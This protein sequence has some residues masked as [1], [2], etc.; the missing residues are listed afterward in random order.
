MCLKRSS[1]RCM[2]SSEPSS[3]ESAGAK[4]RAARLASVAVSG[5]AVAASAAA[6]G[7]KAAARRQHRGGTGD[8]EPADAPF[9]KQTAALLDRKL[10]ALLDWAPATEQSLPEETDDECIRVFRRIKT[11]APVVLGGL[12]AALNVPA[13]PRDA[14]GRRAAKPRRRN[15]SDS[16]DS[17]K[18]RPR[19]ASLGFPLTRD[20]PAPRPSRGHG[21]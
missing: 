12:L 21:R 10:A 14:A 9:Q 7:V 19:S 8:T 17:S 2:S 20:A 5:A 15:A 11:G 1:R 3:S 16:E 6:E 4:A 13:Q 18:V